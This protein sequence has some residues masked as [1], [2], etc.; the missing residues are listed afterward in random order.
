LQIISVNENAD[1][2]VNTTISMPCNS[3][4]GDELGNVWKLV[5]PYQEMCDEERVFNQATER[6]ANREI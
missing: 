4:I 1:G 2:E 6:L 3:E 5:G